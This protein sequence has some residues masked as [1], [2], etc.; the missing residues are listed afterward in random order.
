MGGVLSF[1]QIKSS[2]TYIAPLYDV[3]R[4][5]M[6]G[7]YAEG[8]QTKDSDIDLLVEFNDDDKVTLFTIFRL[9]RELEE[10][11]GKSVDVIAAPVSE[12]SFLVINKEVPIYG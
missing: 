5:S 8:N 10:A 3:K 6:F 4:V 2:V 9:Q 1:D 7:S 12:E 11:V